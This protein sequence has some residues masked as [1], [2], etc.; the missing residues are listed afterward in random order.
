MQHSPNGDENR[1]ERILSRVRTEAGLR[2]ILA[3]GLGRLWLVLLELFAI[4]YKTFNRPAAGIERAPTVQ[5]VNARAPR[6]AE[7]GRNGKC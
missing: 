1:V 4:A 5:G 3:F 7:G 2:D 6:D